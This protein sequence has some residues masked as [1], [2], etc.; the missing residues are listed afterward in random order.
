MAHAVTC[1]ECK[2]VLK[3]GTP[4]PAGKPIKCPKCGADFAAV[5]DPAEDETVLPPPGGLAAAAGLE[6]PA[7]GP[8]GTVEKPAAKKKA[9][10]SPVSGEGAGA[11][12]KQMSRGLLYGLIGGGALLLTCCC[13]CGV[14]GPAVW[15]FVWPR[16]QE[17]LLVGR[18]RTNFL[19]YEFRADKKL[20]LRNLVNGGH[21]DLVYRVDGP[22]TIEVKG[23]TAG[24]NT[25]NGQPYPTRRFEF[26]LTGDTL[27]LRE[28]TG[29]DR[30]PIVFKRG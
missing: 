8:G 1:P 9:D 19:E 11:K 16:G 6:A 23:D 25:L 3:S 29:D 21:F 26:T 5:P 4:V 2:A 24:E 15:Y 13:S 17:A 18:W 22:N 20:K 14:G 7:A 28:L 12:P 30:E 10:G 27:T